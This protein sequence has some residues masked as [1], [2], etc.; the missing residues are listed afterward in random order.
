MPATPVVP[1]DRADLA[2]ERFEP[3]PVRRIE[4]RAEVEAAPD[5]WPFTLPAVAQV[6]RE[7]LDL[8]RATVLVGPNGSGKS[9]LVEAIAMAF[10]LAPEGGSTGARH[11]TYVSESPLHEHLQVIRGPGGSRWGY[12][13][14]AETLHGLV[15]YLDATRADALG[16][17]TSDPVFHR[18]SHGETFRALLDTRRFDGPGLYVL[19]EPEAGLAFEAQLTLVGQLAALARRR[20]RQVLLAT[21]SPIV[22]ALPGAGILERGRGGIRPTSWDRLAVVDHYRRF[23]AGPPGYLRHV[24]G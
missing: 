20:G 6:A 11:R 10:G 12:F 21:H 2:A 7:G 15:G 18:L 1:A 4:L 17:G 16:W 23:L 8:G 24:T 22:A 3:L 9:T 13:V 19:D 14:R 5:R